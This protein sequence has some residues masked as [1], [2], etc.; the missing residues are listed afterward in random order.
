VN[1]LP[2][3]F[4]DLFTNDFYGVELSAASSH[5]EGDFL[6]CLKCG[7]LI[8]GGNSIVQAILDHA[9]DCRVVLF[10]IITGQLATLVLSFSFGLNK[11]RTIPPIYVTEAGD[12]SVGW[13]LQLPLVLSQARH[14]SLLSEV[15]TGEYSL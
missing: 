14:H 3:R 6:C 15:L 9:R 2:V 1:Q 7:T 8:S 4:S 13:S 10:M 5:N 11:V 12:E